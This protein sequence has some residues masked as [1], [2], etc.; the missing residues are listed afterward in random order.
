MIVEKL[1][2]KID[3]NKAIKEQK[4][5]DSAYSLFSMK[6]I[7]N[8][9]IQDIVDEAGVAKG[10]FYLYFKDKYDLQEVLIARKSQ[11]LFEK[12][13]NELDKNI[14]TNF[15]DQLV[16]VI[17]NVINQL[18]K[19]NGLIK[20]IYKDLS[21]GFYNKEISNII[22]NDQIGIYDTFMKGIKENNVKLENPEITL[23]MII[24]LV[25]STIFSS[26][27]KKVPAPIDEFKPHLYKAI[28]MLLNEK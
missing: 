8:T 26:I 27:I 3:S 19:N 9:S 24:E 18:N 4:L 12:A 5:L 20:L 14:L 1:K 2:N 16:F 7:N 28:R 10:T 6:G 21:L 22:D 15:S 25:S 23:Y 11:E 13:I 17:D